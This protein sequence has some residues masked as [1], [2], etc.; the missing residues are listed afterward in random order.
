MKNY[1]ELIE[2][3][4]KPIPLD[5]IKKLMST[6]GK[7]IIGKTLSPQQIVNV[8]NKVINT[9]FDVKV[10]KENVEAIPEGDMNINAFY[11]AFDDE[12]GDTAIELQLLFNP[13]DKKMN[14]GRMGFEM[15]TIQI[16]QA[17][18]HELIHQ[19]QF[20]NRGF[21]KQRKFTR[22]TSKIE[23]IQ[24]VQ[25]YIGDDDEIEAIGL[26]ISSDIK[27][28]FDGDKKQMMQF[29]KSAKD[30]KT[31]VNVSPPMAAYL[32]AFGWEITHPVLKKLYRKITLFINNNI[33]AI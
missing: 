14:I 3:I 10:T 18:Q 31:I 21:R 5:T 12:E 15:L 28:H 17:L 24:R 1:Q 11:S 32:G 19:S 33:D 13:K 27:R 8:F 6:T 30:R 2:G 25:R 16:A 26:N 9:R 29:L 4:T 23:H 20:N 7:K 22:V